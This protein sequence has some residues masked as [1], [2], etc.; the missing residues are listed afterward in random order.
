[1]SLLPAPRQIGLPLR[2]KAQSVA[3][4]WFFKANMTPFRRHAR[5]VTTEMQPFDYTILNLNLKP[6]TLVESDL[7]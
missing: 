3:Q 2:R 7:Y 1:M 6:P 5:Q 4:K